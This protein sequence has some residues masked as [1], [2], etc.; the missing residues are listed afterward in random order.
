MKAGA[1][2]DYTYLWWDELHFTARMHRV[3]A[4]AAAA[5]LELRVLPVGC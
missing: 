5:L 3:I 4:E 1:I 2:E